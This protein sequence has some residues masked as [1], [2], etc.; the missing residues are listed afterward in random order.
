MTDWSLAHLFRHPVKGLG[1][2]AL[3]SVDL[4]KGK[5]FPWDRRWAVAHGNAPAVT[6]WAPPKTFVNQNRVSRLA[7]I[8]V[9]FNPRNHLLELTHP[10]APDLSIQPGTPDGDDALAE[11]IEP[12]VE[13][14]VL[15]GPFLIYAQPD[16]AFT[17]FE[18]TDIS[19]GSEA[20]R[21][22]LGEIAGSELAHIRFRM[23]LWLEG[24][25]P[26]E[27][28]DLVGRE[29]EV[30]SARLKIIERVKRC[31]ATTANPASGQRDVQIPA[32]LH[33]KFGHMDF[34]IYAQV[35]QSGTVRTGDTARLV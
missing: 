31:A 9:R 7:Q 5:P 32:L 34:G 35:V 26:W 17:D 16:G 8:N 14:T 20:S 4:A 22:A 30:G 11:W 33:E 6:G 19:I 2:E 28:F 18:E 3:D 13:G 27:E 24:L 25:A 10:D 1:E 29:V 15:S 23:N 12:L 21:R